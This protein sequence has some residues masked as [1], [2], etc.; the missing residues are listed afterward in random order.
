MPTTVKEA[1]QAALAEWKANT[2][3]PVTFEHVEE[4]VA[5]VQQLADEAVMEWLED[6]G[7]QLHD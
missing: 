3:E 4:W 2:P 5:S 1:V 6:N 7:L